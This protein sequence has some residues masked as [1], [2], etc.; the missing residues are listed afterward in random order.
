MI[1]NLIGNSVV[2]HKGSGTTEAR[3]FIAPLEDASRGLIPRTQ[4]I[5]TYTVHWYTDTS[6]FLLLWPVSYSKTELICCKHCYIRLWSIWFN[7]LFFQLLLV[8]RLERLL[9]SIRISHLYPMK[10]QEIPWNSME[11][12]PPQIIL[13][14]AVLKCQFFIKYAYKSNKHTET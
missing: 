14:A 10:S 13:I 6:Q 1:R 3:G 2:K 4:H 9:P 5:P 12:L 11:K 8:L 7:Y